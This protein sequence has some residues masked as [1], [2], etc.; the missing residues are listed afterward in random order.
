[1]ISLNL[2]SLYRLKRHGL[3]R[4]EVFPRELAMAPLVEAVLSRGQGFLNLPDDASGVDEI[5]R[6]AKSVKGKFQ[7]IVVLG[8]G[9]S[10]LGAATLFAALKP[11][12]FNEMNLKARGGAP[13]LH[14]LDNVDPELIDALDA[15]LDYSKTLFLVITKSG[16]TPETISQYLYFRKKMETLLGRKKAAA[17]VVFVTD[18][19]RGFLRDLALKEHVAT[20]SIPENV[21]GRFSVLSAVG[22]LPA[23]L[24]G[25]DIRDLLFGASAARKNFFEEDSEK[26]LSYSLARVQFLLEQ[27]HGIDIAVMMPYASALARMSDWYRQLLAESIGKIRT[28][29][30]RHI[31]AGLTP[32]SALGVTD[33]HSQVQLYNEGPFDK[34]LIFIEV[35]TF[36]TDV[37]I[38]RLSSRG[39]AARDFDFLRNVSFEQLMHTEKMATES[40]LRTYDRPSLTLS[41]PRID[42]YHVGEFL[43]I[44]EC[45]V[46]LLGEMYGVNAF[47]QPG[48]E[49]AKTNTK[50]MLRRQ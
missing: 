2:D 10:A 6:F 40:A 4:K 17:H 49:L 28:R 39:V 8:I 20:F 26:N 15:I 18:A 42:A 44:L 35:E 22:L 19:S 36:R 29:D 30:G 33:Q 11:L 32:V 41:L 23:A 37:K 43:M 46:A 3:T 14:I 31:Y 27:K 5:L 38:P 21:G 34:L 25:I 47:D 16:T 12:Y 1:M 24:V 13:T 9:G 48:V 45:S 7:H 50:K